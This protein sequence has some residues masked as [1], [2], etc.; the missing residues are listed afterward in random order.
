M[1]DKD[2]LE[3]MLHELSD[4]FKMVDDK[5]DQGISSKITPE[6]QKRLD[7]VKEMV[8][9]FSDL[10]AQAFESAGIT[11]EQLRR[12]VENPSPDLSDKEKRL[13]EFSK[14]LKTEVEAAKLQL[15][16][17]KETSGSIYDADRRDKTK[18]QEIK[19]RKKKFKRL[20]GDD[21]LPL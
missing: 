5:K 9:K 3:R 11:E 4:L 12:M 17:I 8:E 13:L 14:T 10:N 21:W 7:H 19:E 1:A 6:I 15:E 18:K 20:G 16:L 2:Y